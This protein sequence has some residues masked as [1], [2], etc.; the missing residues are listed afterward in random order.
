MENNVITF[1]ILTCCVFIASCSDNKEEPAS[2]VGTWNATSLTEDVVYTDLEKEVHNN[3]NI[4]YGSYIWDL[5]ENKSVKITG[6]DGGSYQWYNKGEEPTEYQSFILDNSQMKL[7][8][9]FSDSLKS[10]VI[11]DVLELSKT[12]MVL[13][14]TATWMNLGDGE[15]IITRT[16]TF[17][18][19]N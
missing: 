5:E 8:F 9:N 17:D 14:N 18:K 7:L 19:I 3:I 16:I 2:I 6:N 12:E 15:V 10:S 1:I 4:G 13:R 11:Y